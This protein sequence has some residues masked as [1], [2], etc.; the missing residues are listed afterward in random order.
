MHFELNFGQRARAEAKDDYV[1][2][3]SPH[4]LSSDGPLAF[5]IGLGKRFRVLW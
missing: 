1:R 3:G 2:P 4:V 5:C